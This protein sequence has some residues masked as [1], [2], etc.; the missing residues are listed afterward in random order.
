MVLPAGT[1]P[2]NPAEFLEAEASKSLLLHLAGRADIKFSST[3]RHFFPSPTL[4]PFHRVEGMV[5]VAH[6]VDI[7][8]R[9]AVAEM[10][11]ILEHVSPPSLA[12]C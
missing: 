12:S 1:L 10:A 2:P 4:W 6:G 9:P 11:R 5:I 7:L 3:R 8:Q